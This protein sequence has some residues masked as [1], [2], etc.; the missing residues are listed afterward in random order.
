MVNQIC[1]ILPGVELR[2]RQCAARLIGRRSPLPF[3]QSGSEDDARGSQIFSTVRAPRDCRGILAPQ[4]QGRSVTE[5]LQSADNRISCWLVGV[6]LRFAAYKTQA[7]AH[8]KARPKLGVRGQ[9]GLLS[10]AIELAGAGAGDSCRIVG[11]TGDGLPLWCDETVRLLQC[12]A[13]IIRWPRHHPPRAGTLDGKRGFWHETRN[14]IPVA[15]AA[16][17]PAISDDEILPIHEGNTAQIQFMRVN[18]S[19]VTFV[20]Q[21]EGQDRSPDWNKAPS[22]HPNH[23]QRAF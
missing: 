15:F 5:T 16:P 20:E 22:A 1:T 2:Q 7:L 23:P 21:G 17:R 14:K 9:G 18:A 6:H 10:K 11:N 4:N 12:V 13:N 8:L 19:C 3:F